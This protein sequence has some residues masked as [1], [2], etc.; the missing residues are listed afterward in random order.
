M[1]MTAQQKEQIVKILL[2]F[3]RDAHGV[4]KTHKQKIANYIA[5]ADS[6]RA[7]TILEEIKKS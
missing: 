5:T 2:E 6:T 3:K 7:K 1:P 4:V